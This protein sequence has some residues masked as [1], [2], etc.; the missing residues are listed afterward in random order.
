MFVLRLPIT[1][2]TSIQGGGALDQVFAGLRYIQGNSVLPAL[3]LLTLV[4]VLFSMPYMM[5]MPMFTTD[6]IIV[7]A[8]EVAWMTRLPVLGGLL[9]PLP[10]GRADDRIWYRSAGGLTGYRRHRR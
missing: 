5:L 1:G 10:A 7:N 2:S 4:S 3:L 6:I 8:T 9:A